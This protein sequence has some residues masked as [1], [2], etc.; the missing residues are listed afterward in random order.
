M[1]GLGS[2]VES[3]YVEELGLTLSREDIY[4]ILVLDM[5]EGALEVDW[6]DFFP[7]LRWFPNKSIE[8]K[9]QRMHFRRKVVMKALINEQKKRIASGK[10]IKAFCMHIYIY[11]RFVLIC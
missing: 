9:I 7:Y 2:D 11:N 10:V 4:K 6:R 3:I 5:M 8:M 1:Q